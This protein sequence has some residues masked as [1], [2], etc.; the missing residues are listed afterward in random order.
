MPQRLR[1][2]FSRSVCL[3]SSLEESRLTR[4]VKKHSST[5]VSSVLDWSANENNPAR[6][7]YIVLEKASGQ[8][9]NEVCDA[10]DAPQQSMLVRKFAEMESKLS[11]VRFPG[12]GALYLRDALPAALRTHARTRTINIDDTYCLG[13]MYHGAWPGGFSAD[14]DA[15]AEYSGPCISPL[16]FSFTVHCPL[17]SY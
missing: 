13:P 3:S 14:P 17:S 8:Q 4:T 5:P 10:L 2:P 16:L 11:T 7:E 1:W 6:T 15:Y 12:Y 9:L